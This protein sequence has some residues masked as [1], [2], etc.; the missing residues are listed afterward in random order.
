MGSRTWAGS[1][2]TRTTIRP[3][4]RSRRIRKAT[5]RARSIA[6]SGTT[7]GVYGLSKSTAGCGVHA[8]ADAASGATYGVYGLSK[9]SQGRGVYGYANAR[10]GT[11]YGV[12]GQSESTKGRGVYGYAS[13][14]SDST[15]GAKGDADATFSYRLVARRLGYEGQPLERAPWADDDPNP[16]PEKRAEW[17]VQKELV[18]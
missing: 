17:E 6:T 18:E 9:S 11:T 15:Y 2:S 5:H 14:S 8:T 13:A 3:W 12:Y 10:S 4:F 16:Y 7:C 1:S